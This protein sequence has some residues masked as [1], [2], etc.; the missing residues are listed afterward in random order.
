VEDMTAFDPD[1]Y[2]GWQSIGDLEGFTFEYTYRFGGVHTH[3]LEYDGEE[4]RGVTK[5]NSQHY[6][7]CVFDAITDT[8]VSSSFTALQTGLERVVPRNVLRLFTAAELQDL[9]SGERIMD[10]AGTVNLLKEIT[11]YD[12]YS[13]DDRVI[14]NLWHVLS[15]GTVDQLSQFLDLITA[16]DRLPASFPANFKLTIFK[17]GTDEEMFPR[18]Q[19]CMHGLGL[20]AY[21]SVG[22]LREKLFMALENFAVPGGNAFHLD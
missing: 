9:L 10:V 3:I 8:L 19:T 20:P 15:L 4:A 18:G 2:R 5:E 1:L 21:S 7:R 11:V 13:P 22:K 12:G 17:S 16:T 6:I 14:Q